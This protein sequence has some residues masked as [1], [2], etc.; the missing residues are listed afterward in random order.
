MSGNGG[1]HAVNISNQILEASG[2]EIVIAVSWMDVLAALIRCRR[3]H[4][5]L[6][7]RSVVAP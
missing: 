7:I 6:T 4:V 2:G 3:P 5:R 1:G